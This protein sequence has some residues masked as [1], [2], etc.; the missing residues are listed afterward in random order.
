MH[1]RPSL[2]G[3]SISREPRLKITLWAFQSKKV[4]VVF[5]FPFSF[6]RILDPLIY[7]Y[8]K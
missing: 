6:S 8:L 5:F 2:P 1:P 4:N 7:Q 3:L